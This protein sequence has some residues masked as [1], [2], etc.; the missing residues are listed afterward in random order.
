MPTSASS[1]RW[2]LRSPEREP[3]RS[4]R[5]IYNMSAERRPLRRAWTWLREWFWPVYALAWVIGAVVAAFSGE[6][7]RLIIVMVVFGGFA[8]FGFARRFAKPS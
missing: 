4:P 3:F 5:S 6:W 8:V 1:L 7:F 2:P